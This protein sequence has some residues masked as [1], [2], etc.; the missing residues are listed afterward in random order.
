MWGWVLE[1]DGSLGRGGSP[2]GSPPGASGEAAGPACFTGQ[3]SHGGLRPPRADR[4][5]RQKLTPG[6][7][8]PV[9]LASK[10]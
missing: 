3:E 7:C 9:G 6:I 8:D 10:G 5:Q 2:R 1:A 4:E